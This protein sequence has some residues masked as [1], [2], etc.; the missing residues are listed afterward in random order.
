M[1][2]GYYQI[3]VDEKDVHKTAFVISERHY[4]LKKMPFCL[5]KCTHNISERNDC[6]CKSSHVKAYL[7]QLLFFSKS[8]E[9]HY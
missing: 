6:F 8:L 2:N 1:N 5:K 3:P 7:N 4:E 9:K